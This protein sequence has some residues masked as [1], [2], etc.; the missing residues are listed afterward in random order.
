MWPNPSRK[1]RDE[2][3]L[4]VEGKMADSNVAMP[5]A[6]GNE[7]QKEDYDLNGGEEEEHRSHQTGES[8]IRKED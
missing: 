1:N 5:E 6:E 7:K 3:V 2:V 8:G 4:W